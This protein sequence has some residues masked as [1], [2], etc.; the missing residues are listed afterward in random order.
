[1]FN[2]I[3]IAIVAT[4]DLA[5][6]PSPTQTVGQSLR[7]LCEVTAVRGITSGVDIVW[8]SGGVRLNRTNNVSPTTKDNSLVYTDSY[9]ISQLNTTDNG[10]VIQCRVVINTSPSVMASDSITLNVTGKYI[11]CNGPYSLLVR[12]SYFISCSYTLDLL[13]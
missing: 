8:R 7:L 6:I 12:A 9:T 1:M 11:N 13:P 5:V 4:P 2:I 10:R 3:V